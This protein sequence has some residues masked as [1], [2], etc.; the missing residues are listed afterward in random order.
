MIR[1][2]VVATLVLGASFGVLAGTA[3]AD[4]GDVLCVYDHYPLYM[5]WCVSV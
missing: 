3:S 1:R 5:G 4:D 2:V